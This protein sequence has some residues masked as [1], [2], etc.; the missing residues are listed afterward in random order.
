M[1]LR[2]AYESGCGLDEI[3]IG[4]VEAT[5][6]D[7]ERLPLEPEGFGERIAAFAAAGGA[8]IAPERKAAV[9]NM[10]RYGTYKPA[11]RAKPSSEYLALAASENDFPRVNYFVDAINLASLLSGFPISLIDTDKSGLEILLRRGLDGEEYVFN[12]GGQSIALKD[13]LC[14]CR[15][16]PQGYIPTAN[17]VRD[18]METKLFPGA[19]RLA[20]FVYAPAEAG[21]GMSLESTCALLSELFGKAT[22]SVESAMAP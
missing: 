4:I 15:K 1:D 16:G 9:R 7:W 13:L 6:L 21:G 12:S 18:S 20:A 5:G 17:P 8:A 3:R 19:A 2:V 11:G 10:L 22:G 14:L